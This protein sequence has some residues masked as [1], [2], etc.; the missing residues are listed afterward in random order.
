MKTPLALLIAALALV[1]CAPPLGADDITGSYNLVSIDGNPL[2]FN[3]AH[4]VG[5]PE[6]ISGTLT[7]AGDGTFQMT[8][9]FAT[10]PNDPVSR[11]MNGSYILEEGVLKLDWQGSGVTPATVDNRSITL[12]NEGLSFLYQR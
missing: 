9:T 12:V 1:A 11:S 3:P 6:V 7:L 4:E 8:M 5:A 10:E 2:P